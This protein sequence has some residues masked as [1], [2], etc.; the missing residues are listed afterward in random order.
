TKAD[1]PEFFT[2]LI[3]LLDA[4]PDGQLEEPPLVWPELA[5]Y[6]VDGAFWDL[7]A[8]HFGWRDGA[9]SL[10]GLL[11][12]LMVCDLANAVGSALP[13]GLAHL[14]LPKH[15]VANAVVCLAQWR[16]SSARGPSYE[17]LS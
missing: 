5:K 11:I 16:D 17:R 14:V 15:G 3:T 1:H 7:V 13:A 9:P 10:K 6:G 4:I 2:L 12:R 8:E